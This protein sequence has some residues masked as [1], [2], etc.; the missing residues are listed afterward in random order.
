[1]LFL[2]YKCLCLCV[3]VCVLGVSE[4]GGQRT[5]SLELELQV[6]LDPNSGP[7]NRGARAPVLITEQHMLLPAAPALQPQPSFF[8][9]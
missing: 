9:F 1:M 3:N 7:H 5:G 2:T 8:P 4:L 6:V